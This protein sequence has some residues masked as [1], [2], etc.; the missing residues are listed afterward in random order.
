MPSVSA[1]TT[2][3][4]DS[5]FEQALIDLN[6]DSNGLNGNIL[7]ADAASVISLNVFDKGITNMA[8]IEAF[9]GLK[10][11]FCFNNNI[12]QIDL[13]SNS[14]LKVLD[15]ENNQIAAI[16]LTQNSNLRELY[17]S[18][19]QLTAINVSS[20]ALLEVLSCNLNN[21]STIDVANNPELEVLWFYSNSVATID[22][23]NNP[24]LESL[25]CGDNGMSTLDISNNLQLETLSCDNNNLSSLSL[26][27]N[28]AIDYLSFSNNGLSSLDLSTTPLVKRLLCNNNNLSVLDVTNLKDL[29]LLHAQDNSIN[30]LDLS[31]N[32][33]VKHILAYNNN[34]QIVDMRNGH[35]HIVSTFD[36]TQNANLSCLF[37]DHDNAPYL[38]N[39][40]IDSNCAFVENEAQC[41][42]L[43]V[44]EEA[45]LDF[46]FYPN[47][48][49]GII[50]LTSPY[51]NATVTLYTL[52]GQQLFSRK[53]A[54]GDNKLQLEQMQSGIY[55]LTVSS[56]NTFQ[57]KKLVLQ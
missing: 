6:I 13:S 21:I 5:N 1:Q 38:Q 11:L 45:Q 50:T 18:N 54:F 24:Q 47:P 27:N 22:L 25:F 17:I 26:T 41:N 46:S 9:T 30:S 55:L 33:K 36:M 4:P 20:N 57:T 44:A 28:T 15:I 8:G 42:A 3:I 14:L 31:D 32:N 56:E 10:N 48:S 35:N 51:Q 53:L 40:D 39:W 49:S 37:V 29:F 7:N 34:L 12:P 52:G 23:S 2:S 43:S 16:D 19:N